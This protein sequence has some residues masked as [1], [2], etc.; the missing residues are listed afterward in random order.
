MFKTVSVDIMKGYIHLIIP[1]IMTLLHVDYSEEKARTL[2]LLNTIGVIAKCLD[3]FLHIIVP[4]IVALFE[5]TEN[6][7][8]L[9]LAAMQA[10]GILCKN[11][12]F[13]YVR[14]TKRK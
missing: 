8:T 3:E 1:K 9:R 6:S 13:R 4:A 2:T 14:S 10:L 11:L 5:N 7:I 12:N